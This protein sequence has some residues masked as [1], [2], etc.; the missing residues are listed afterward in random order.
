MGTGRALR[1]LE[2]HSAFVD[3]VAVTPDGQRAVSASR[4]KTLR[5]WDLQTGLLIATFH[6][7]TVAGCCAFVDNHRIL[8]GDYGGRLYL[9]SLEQPMVR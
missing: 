2:G 7:E 8:L 9:L 4:D 3:R 5:V 6:C 1:A